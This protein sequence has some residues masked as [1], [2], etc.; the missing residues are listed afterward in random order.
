M[1]E[2]AGYCQQTGL[3]LP[4]APLSITLDLP[5]I[6]QGNVKFLLHMM[7]LICFIVTFSVYSESNI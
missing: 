3:H 2:R 7:V 6:H 1:S 5:N 4:S